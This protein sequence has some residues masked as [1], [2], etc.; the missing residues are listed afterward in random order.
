LIGTYPLSYKTIIK[1]QLESCYHETKRKKRRFFFKARFYTR[2][3]IN[4]S[5]WR[6][7]AFNHLLPLIL[8]VPSLK[9]LQLPGQAALERSRDISNQFPLKIA[10]V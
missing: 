8:M 10:S 7:S 9:I 1:M 6:K 3:I 5:L 4:K 2:E